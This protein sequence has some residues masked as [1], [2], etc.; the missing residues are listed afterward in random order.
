MT[1]KVAGNA[2]IYVST[3]GKARLMRAESTTNGTLNFTEWDSVVPTSTPP[4]DQLA[5]IPNL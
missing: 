4:A 3:D 2:T 5:K 1:T